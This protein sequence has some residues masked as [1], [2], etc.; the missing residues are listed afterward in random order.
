MKKFLFKL[1]YISPFALFAAILMIA[2]GVKGEPMNLSLAAWGLGV[3]VFSVFTFPRPGHPLFEA[4]AKDRASK[5]EKSQAIETPNRAEEYA[6]WDASHWEECKALGSSQTSPDGTE[7]QAPELEDPHEIELKPDYSGW[8]RLDPVIG[9][10]DDA[11]SWLGGRPKMP[12]DIMW[13]QKNGHHAVFAAQVAI[14]DLPDDIWGGIGPKSGWLLFFMAPNLKGTN[15]IHIDQLGPERDYPAKNWFMNYLDSGPRH[16]LASCGRY[17]RSYE[18][19]KWGVNINATDKYP[20][21]GYDRS[22]L[23]FSPQSALKSLDLTAQQLSE[24]GA[25]PEA[26][27]C[28]V[29][30]LA[31]EVYCR[32]P[33][34]L[35][36]EI[37]TAVEADW[38][39]DAHYEAASM[40]GPFPSDYP[41]SDPD[42]PVLLLQLQSS[43]LIGWGF[44]DL[45]RCAFFIKPS[46]LKAGRWHKA[47]FDVAN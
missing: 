19:P 9:P 6:K 47:W 38:Q 36:P 29:D 21:G 45:G 37:R 10:S 14:A 40:S 26:D 2:S 18:P 44:G 22:G 11:T 33:N 39:G 1:G 30:F 13:P 31:R 17:L 28:T 32:N 5:T 24:L 35:A 7:A 12:D 27:L 16:A 42:D 41:Y 8:C 20:P 23:D 3:L 46:D 25:P 4:L 34:A 15:V 43:G